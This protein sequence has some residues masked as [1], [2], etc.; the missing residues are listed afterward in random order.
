M[1]LGIGADII[2]VTRVGRAAGKPSFARKVFDPRE[3]EYC[4]SKG[5]AMAQSFAGCFAAKEAFVKALGT[6]FGKI[7]PRDI[8]ILHNAEGRPYVK[9][10]GAAL[11][12]AVSANVKRVFLTITHCK[13]YAA[14]HIILEG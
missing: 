3:R 14:A 5:A 2:E 10:R 6:G 1:I 9:L 4:G 8:V 7:T 12:L 13:E 11:K